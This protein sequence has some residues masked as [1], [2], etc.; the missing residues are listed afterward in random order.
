SLQP[1]S[2]A[3]VRRSS[4]SPSTTPAA[5]GRSQEV[6]PLIPEEHLPPALPAPKP[7]EKSAPLLPQEPEVKTPETAA[8]PK[9]AA[10]SP[11]QPDA[12]A[13]VPAPAA[14]EAPKIPEVP[15]AF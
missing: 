15:V 11:P 13:P 14:A 7:T 10:L 2:S 6:Q 4:V 8:P 9:M 5:A 1:N 12:P 3:L